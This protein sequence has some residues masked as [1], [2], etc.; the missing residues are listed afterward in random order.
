MHSKDIQKGETAA[1]GD[2]LDVG[3]RE[4]GGW[5]EA[6]VSDLGGWVGGKAIHQEREHRKTGTSG[7]MRVRVQV[8]AC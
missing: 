8:P 7:R 6:Q 1:L 5:E 3:M 4:R 2:G